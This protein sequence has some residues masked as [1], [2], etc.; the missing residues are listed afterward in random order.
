MKKEEEEMI[1]PLPARHQGARG[2]GPVLA[3]YCRQDNKAPQGRGEFL[4]GLCLANTEHH[5]HGP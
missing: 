1:P 2:P 5:F 4:Q 3:A